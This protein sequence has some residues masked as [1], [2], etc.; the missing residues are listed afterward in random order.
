MALRQSPLAAAHDELGARMTE[1]GGWNMPVQFESIKTEHA[2]VREDAGVFD[3][4]HMGE[5]VVTGPDAGDLLNSLTTNDV[6]TL[7]RGDVQYACIC[8]GDGAIVDDTVVYHRPEGGYMFVPN[9]GQS[10]EMAGNFRTFA[11]SRDLT[12][13]VENRTDDLGMLAVQGPEAERHVAA[14]TADPVAD[15]EQFTAH[16]TTIGGVDCLVSRTGYT[17]ED[18]FEIVFPS[19][20]AEPVWAAFDDVQPCGLGARDTLRL[21]AGLL[22][23]GQD[24]HP[25]REPRTPYEA[26]LGFVVALDT[27]FVGRD[28]LA[29]QHE[30]GVVE[31]LVGVELDVRGV[32]RHDCPILVDGEEVG[33]VTSGTLSPTLDVPI[34]VGYVDA[35]YAEAGTDAAVEIRGTAKAATITNQRFLQRHRD[36]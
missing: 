29:K 17:G 3:V 14:A 28:A 13:T 25:M 18:G 7:D 16:R 19:E 21:E 15:A 33:H 10:G 32:P 1:F 23:S 2:A 26:N 27:E 22:L 9:A 11:E 6:S 31:Q 12:A 24:F 20:E 8:R 35:A 34:G 36:T 30:T 5:V 4:S